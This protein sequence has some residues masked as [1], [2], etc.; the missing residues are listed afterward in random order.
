MPGWEYQHAEE[1][2]LRLENQRASYAEEAV[3]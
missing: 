2:S 1:A 3:E